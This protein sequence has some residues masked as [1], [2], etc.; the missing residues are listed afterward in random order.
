MAKPKT[1]T[2]RNVSDA[3]KS[4]FVNGRYR[5]VKVGEQIETGDTGTYWQTGEQGEP[6]IW[7]LVGGPTEPPASGPVA[8]DKKES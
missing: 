7:E 4:V 2:Y 5:L 3:D 8:T 1:N 6:R